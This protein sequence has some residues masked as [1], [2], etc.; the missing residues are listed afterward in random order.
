MQRAEE[1]FLGHILREREI[2]HAEQP[3]Q[4]AVQ[5]SGL[6]TEEMFHQFG[7]RTRHGRQG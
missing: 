3:D 4:S 5:S 7:W 2:V 1:S 6:V